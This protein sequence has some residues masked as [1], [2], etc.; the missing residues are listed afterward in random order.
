MSPRA[1]DE[2]GYCCNACAVG[3]RVKPVPK[4]PY[5]STQVFR[6]AREGGRDKRMEAFCAV[7]EED[8]DV[9]RNEEAVE[10]TRRWLRTPF[11]LIAKNLNDAT[12]VEDC[13][14]AR[15]EKK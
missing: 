3:G 5:E 7:H 11:I 9:W 15:K 8:R 1:I 12:G 6:W 14:P 2:E 10:Q 4:R 13:F